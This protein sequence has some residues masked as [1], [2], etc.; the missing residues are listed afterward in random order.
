[1]MTLSRTPRH[2]RI[3]LV[4]VAMLVAIFAVA[5]TP[6]IGSAQSAPEGQTYMQGA[7]RPGIRGRIMAALMQGITLSDQQMNAINL[8][9]ANYMQQMQQARINQDV[10]EIQALVIKQLG[11][12][13]LVL[14]P[15]QQ[16][17]FDKNV[18][19]I[20]DNRAANGAGQ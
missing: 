12:I 9:R 4:L 5:S 19:R 8:I 6:A 15:D 17:I 14:T 7:A 13:R 18:Q 11:D 1:M 16:P 10:E 2:H 3:T 20:R